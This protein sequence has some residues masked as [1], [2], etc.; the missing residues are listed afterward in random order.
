MDQENKSKNGISK[1]IIISA[2][3]VLGVAVLI[4]SNLDSPRSEAAPE[5]GNQAL[6]AE[7]SSQSQPENRVQVFVFHATQRCPS[8]V[9]IGKFASSTINEFFRSELASGQIEFREVNIDLLENKELAQKFRAAG[10]SLFINSI[11][12][13]QDNIQED[14]DVWRYVFQEEQFKAYL[15]EKISGLLSN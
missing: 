13:G 2:I 8:C 6:K 4:L 3:V 5:G 11:K 1:K 7:S 14:T 15:K 10:S 9:A 12:N